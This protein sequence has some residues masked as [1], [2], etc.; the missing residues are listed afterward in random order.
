VLK[1]VQYGGERNDAFRGLIC[2]FNIIPQVL[3]CGLIMY[4]CTMYPLKSSNMTIYVYVLQALFQDQITIEQFITLCSS[5]LEPPGDLFVLNGLTDM[6]LAI[7][8]QHTALY[9]KIFNKL[10]ADVAMR[11][12]KIFG[13]THF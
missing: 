12:T 4:A 11:M 13:T 8:S 9:G 2:A 7:Q 5:W 1:A 10:P 3:K 6:L